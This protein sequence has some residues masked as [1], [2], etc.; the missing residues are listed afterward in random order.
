MKRITIIIFTCICSTLMYSCKQNVPSSEAAN[1]TEHQHHEEA[2]VVSLSFAQIKAIELEYGMI[3]NK[4]LTKSLKASG[5]LK[6]P[7]QNRATI[8]AMYGGVVKSILVQP[9]NHVR[10]GQPIV[11]LE[12]PSFVS[13]QEEYLALNSKL[14]YASLEYERLKLL[15]NQNAG[16]LKSAQLAES[17]Y[18][19]MA[20]R[21]A[22]LRKQLELLGIQPD[23][24][25]NETIQSTISISSPVAG[26]VSKVDVNLGASVDNTH[27][28]AEVVDNSQLHLDLYVYEKDLDLVKVGQTIHFT[29]TNNYGK[30]YDAVVFGISN[31]FEGNAKALAVHAMVM[32]EKSGLIDGMS[33]TALLSLERATVPAIPTNAIVNYQGSD[34]I[35]VLDSTAVAAHDSKDVEGGGHASHEQSDAAKGTEHHFLASSSNSEKT[36]LFRKIPI[37]RGTTDVGYSEVTLLSVVPRNTKVVTK[38]AFFL[39][40]SMTNTGEHEH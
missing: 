22:S 23:K 34:Y 24:L 16:S 14:Q 32:G 33:V 1:S 39:L 26:S 3:E 27:S 25:S 31:A 20:T 38:G 5:I 30:E 28:I 21:R 40:S 2:N 13:L 29:L 36:V 18:K 9:G 8:T 35:F 11:L 6:V 37:K 15:S 19:V 4:Q 7:S 12:N 10:K 17:E